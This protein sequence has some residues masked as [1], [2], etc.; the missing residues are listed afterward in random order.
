MFSSEL[1]IKHTKASLCC[2]ET[3]THQFDRRKKM[4][5]IQGV[6]GQFIEYLS[7]NQNPGQC[8][9]LTIDFTMVV[10]QKS[11]K[12]FKKVVT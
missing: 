10:K 8:C 1:K 9:H 7:K 2:S 3:F 4:S 11:N 12:D 6:T 5:C